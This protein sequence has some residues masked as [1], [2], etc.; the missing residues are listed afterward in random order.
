MKNFVKISQSIVSELIAV[1]PHTIQQGFNMLE[2]KGM[3]LVDVTTLRH[4]IMIY[5]QVEKFEYYKRLK[6]LILS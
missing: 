1:L 2:N 3:S 6:M 5:F 4:Y